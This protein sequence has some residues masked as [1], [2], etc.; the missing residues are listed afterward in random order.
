MCPCTEP[1]K[2]DC[3]ARWCQLATLCQHAALGRPE[4]FRQL[5]RIGRV[6]ASLSCCQHGSLPCGVSSHS[7]E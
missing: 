1:S 4:M 6:T 3:A 5:L 7:P 2:S